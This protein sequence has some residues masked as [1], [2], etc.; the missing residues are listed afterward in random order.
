[1]IEVKVLFEITVGELIDNTP[2]DCLQDGVQLAT[3][4]CYTP[5]LS[6]SIY[7]YTYVERERERDTYIYIY[8][9]SGD[10]A[11]R[12]ALGGIQDSSKVGAVETGCSGLYDVIY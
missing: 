5:S 9:L 6:L 8:I 2:Y 11:G 4:R 3:R 12:A 7:I 10:G 1:M